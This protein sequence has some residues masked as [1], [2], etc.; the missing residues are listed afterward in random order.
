MLNENTGKQFLKGKTAI[1]GNYHSFCSKEL[2]TILESFGMR[3]EIF[4]TGSEI[5]EK[6]KNNYKCDVIFTNNVYQSGIQGPELLKE[7]RKIEGFNTPV[8]IHTIDQNRR[9]YFVDYIGFDD[10]L[11]KPI[12]SNNKDKVLEIAN[13]FSKIY[14]INVEKEVV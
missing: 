5:L 8:V 6:I 4:K 2:K 14:S 9:N 12:F 1:I 10:Y 13:I 3:V 11:E 7:L